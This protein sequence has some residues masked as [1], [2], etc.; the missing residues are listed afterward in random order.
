METSSWRNNRHVIKCC[1]DCKPPKRYP[2]CG[3]KCKEYQEEKAKY[4]AEKQKA[5]E[6]LDNHPLITNYD[7]DQVR[8]TASRRRK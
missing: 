6:Y 3:G 5:K 1:K 7:F 4:L 2:G 8:S